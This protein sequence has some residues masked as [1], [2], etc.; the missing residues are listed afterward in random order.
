MRLAHTR[1]LTDAQC[2]SWMTLSLNR[3]LAKID[4]DDPGR[5][6]AQFWTAFCGCYARA[7]LGLTFPTVIL[8]TRPAIADFSNGCGQELCEVSS[9]P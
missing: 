4:A 8:R 1:D 9:K 6:D 5:S 2:R 7:L 3:C